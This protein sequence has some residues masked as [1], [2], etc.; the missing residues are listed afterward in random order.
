[1]TSLK[2][3]RAVGL[4]AHN[5]KRLAIAVEIAVRKGISFGNLR[6]DLDFESNEL[7]YHLE[8]LTNAG[9][10]RKVRTNKS[11]IRKGDEALVG[12]QKTQPP[13]REIYTLT[14]LGKEI[15]KKLDLQHPRNANSILNELKESNYE[16]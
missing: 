7:C 13:Q 12:P 2:K 8:K 16:E 3:L 4:I 9:V 11:I 15:A 5:N 1:M 6:R 14:E 10:I